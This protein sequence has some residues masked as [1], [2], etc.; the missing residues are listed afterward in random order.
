M[1]ISIPKL[2]PSLS[3]LGTPH[4]G[5]GGLLL[6]FFLFT[7][8]SASAQS[9]QHPALVNT[10]ADLDFIKQKVEAKEQPWY[11]AW[12][13]MCN[14]W[15]ANSSYTTGGSTNGDIGG[16]DGNRQRASRDAQ[17][18][19]YNILRWYVTGDEAHAKCAV[20][21]LNKWTETVTEVASEQLYQLP[22][23]S[24]VEAAELV[25]LYDG[26]VQEDREA[27]KTMCLEKWY[28]GLK[29]FLAHCGSW[30]GWDGP[31][32]L[33]CMVVGVFCDR[34]DI[35]DEAVRYYK[36]GAEGT[37]Y[38]GG[39]LTNM[40]FNNKGQSIE[41]GR[42]MP[43]AEI[44]LDA[45]AELCEVAWNN[46]I[47]LWSLEDNL[48]LKGFEY[49]Y[50]Y[51]LEHLCDWTSYNDCADRYFYSVSLNSPYRITGFPGSEATFNHYV[52]RKG[53]D[54]PYI[55]NA[56]RLRGLQN[57]SWDACNY[58]MLTYMDAGIQNYVTA[59]DAPEAPMAVEAT[60]LI[61]GIRLKW[62][63]PD[64]T[65]VSGS[66]IERREAG[67][68]EWTKV[69]E[70]TNNTST[71]YVDTPLVDGKTYEYRIAL[72]NNSAKGE[73]CNVVKA[74]AVEGSAAM[75]DSWKLTDIGSVESEGDA[76]YYEG[77]GHNFSVTSRSYEMRTNGTTDNFSFLYRKLTG[78]FTI[79]GRIYAYDR[80]DGRADMFGLMIRESLAGGARMAAVCQNN[81][82]ARYAYMLAR[83]GAN[84]AT[85]S[86][87]GDT[88]TFV[89]SWFKLVRKGSTFTAYQCFDGI[90]WQEVYTTTISGFASTCYVGMFAS[91]GWSGATGETRVFFDNISVASTSGNDGCPAPTDFMAA[92][93]NATSVQLTW[94]ANDDVSSYSVKCCLPGSDTFYTI[95]DAL[96]G[97]TFTH[98]GLTPETTYR[99]VVIAQNVAGQTSSDTIS[100]TTSQLAAPEMP[101]DVKA[102]PNITYAFLDW[103]AQSDIEEYDISRSL[104]SDNGF[105]VIATVPSGNL[106]QGAAGRVG[107][108][109]LTTSL[110][111]TYYYK[112]R[113]RNSLGESD[114]TEPVMVTVALQ[115]KLAGTTTEGA[116]QGTMLTID[117]GEGNECVVTQVRYKPTA[118]HID[119]FV[120]SVF[121]GSNQAD[122]AE[123]SILH[124]V[125]TRPES[126]SVWSRQSVFDT[127]PYRYLKF[128]SPTEGITSSE[129]AFYGLT[130]EAS[131]IE[132]NETETDT[133]TRWYTVSGVE[134]SK[135]G[136]KGIYI[137]QPP[138]PPVGGTKHL[139]K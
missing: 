69:Y 17:A 49:L 35:F 32:N 67:T 84:A 26:W 44:G 73:Y 41:M 7:T 101:Q 29:N 116:A 80:C 2:L 127:T 55:T 6:I 57:Y 77:N 74:T 70:Y 72:K 71:E 21:I 128:V 90:N 97:N 16:S 42:D 118:A 24:M 110:N 111:T 60:P 76:L 68:E 115:Q 104:S 45:A 133:A 14:E 65:T 39:R 131:G 85:T 66:I 105:E 113:A 123:N 132:L 103:T 81:T 87:P 79:T 50:R 62:Q 120:G 40:I 138:C 38:G 86:W 121:Y 130:H 28:P 37:G 112:V 8:S 135:P 89:G 91:R 134:V 23:I 95:A 1:D 25:S 53:M 15:K 61:G 82:D 108:L 83:K 22:I 109:D 78:S 63:R 126:S 64:W 19:Y 96:T 9:F 137:K 11:G 43:H 18:A 46:G 129:I 48:L 114:Y 36:E 12:Q 139:I 98:N 13:N 125:T 88:H 122:F 94:D 20:N 124:N 136:K 58:T 4:R 27:F 93:V 75:P 107:W 47:D 5:A 30:P 34:Q 99:Y 52:L 100:V 56:I 119:G 3:I 31:A 54:A 92:D 10:R 102:T 33:G 51:N 106:H 117:L 59:L